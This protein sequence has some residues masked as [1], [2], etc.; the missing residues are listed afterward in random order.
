MFDSVSKNSLTQFRE[1]Q[2]GNVD[3]GKTNLEL[4]SFGDPLNGC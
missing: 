4:C 3:V 1:A 2:I